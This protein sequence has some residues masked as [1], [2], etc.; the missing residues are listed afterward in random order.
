M[1]VIYSVLFH[2][3]TS[4]LYIQYF[5]THLLC[6]I[7][8]TQYFTQ[9]IQNSFDIFTFISTIQFHSIY[10]EFHSIIAFRF[11]HSNFIMYRHV[12]PEWSF[13]L[14]SVS[15]VFHYLNL[16]CS[17]TVRCWV[18]LPLIL[19]SHNSDLVGDSRRQVRQHSLRLRADN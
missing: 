6:F 16:T 13:I 11:M 8:C 17:D 3:F 5:T 7:P 2:I 15:F 14:R 9:Y 4:I 12:F 1:K 10:S 19:D 18:T